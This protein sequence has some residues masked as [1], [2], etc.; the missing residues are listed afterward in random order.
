LGVKSVFL[1]C[2]IHQEALCGKIIKMNQT[3]KMVVNIVRLIRGGNKDQRHRAFIALLEEVD[4]DCGD[5]PLHSD[6][7]WLSAGKCLQRSFFVLRKEI[8]L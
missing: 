4:A 2:I 1:H 5:I 3:M 7:T 8:L 6:I